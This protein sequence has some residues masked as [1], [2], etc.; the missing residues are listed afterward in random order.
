MQLSKITPRPFQRFRA[1]YK[2]TL[3]ETMYEALCDPTYSTTAQYALVHSAIRHEE[4]GDSFK[5]LIPILDQRTN[6][7]TWRVLSLPEA[8][9][10]LSLYHTLCENHHRADEVSA[11]IASQ[12]PLSAEHL[13]LE[14]PTTAQV[15]L[16]RVLAENTQPVFQLDLE[17]SPIAG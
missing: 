2:F 10:F 5:L 4:P 13:Q 1:T 15:A 7:F 3:P 12:Q 11:R 9:R 8:G 17:G 16:E 6:P 14:D